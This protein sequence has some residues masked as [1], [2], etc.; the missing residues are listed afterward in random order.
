[1]AAEYSEFPQCCTHLVWSKAGAIL[2]KMFL[3]ESSSPGSCQRL[4]DTY[5]DLDLFIRSSFVESYVINMQLS[6]LLDA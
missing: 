6:G 4:E 1:M 5:Q 2:V 3:A